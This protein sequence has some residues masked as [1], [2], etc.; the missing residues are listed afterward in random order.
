MLN[1]VVSSFIGTADLIYL[2]KCARTQILD[3]TEPLL[4]VPCEGE[5]LLLADLIIVSLIVL[6]FSW[7][8]DIR[9]RLLQRSISRFDCLGSKMSIFFLLYSHFSLEKLLSIVI[10]LKAPLGVWVLSNRG[11]VLLRRFG[12]KSL[13]FQNPL[14]PGMCIVSAATL[15]V[16][17]LLF[18]SG[19]GRR[20]PLSNDLM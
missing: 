2:N 10:A 4:V 7:R 19:F 14:V 11:L 5:L 20:R 13:G 17:P 12:R 15:M 1:Q 8:L 16:A 9:L 18:G 6:C 3:L